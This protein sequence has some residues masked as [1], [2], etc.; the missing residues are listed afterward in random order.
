MIINKMETM[1]KRELRGCMIMMG[2]LLEHDGE[3]LVS[4]SAV[5]AVM[6][7]IAQVRVH[8]AGVSSLGVEQAEGLFHGSEARLKLHLL[9]IRF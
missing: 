5:K 9:H 2:L 1:I 6:I 8:I 3:L 7:H 4:L